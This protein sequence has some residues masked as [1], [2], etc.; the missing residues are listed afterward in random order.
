MSTT[1]E[2]PA[3]A[4]WRAE[5]AKIDLKREG[6]RAA[7]YRAPPSPLWSAGESVA[8]AADAFPYPPEPKEPREVEVHGWW[9]R[10]LPD[11]R[12]Q[13][14]GESPPDWC[15]CNEAMT[16]AG[17]SAFASLLPKADRIRLA[18]EGE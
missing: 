4:A 5:C 11:G 1:P 3:Y 2:S 10:R 18:E 7:C 6:Y 15:W 17:V 9:Y 16:D 12:W 8:A 14:R 13:Y